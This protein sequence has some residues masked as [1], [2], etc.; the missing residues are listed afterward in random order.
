MK[1]SEDESM[2]EENREEELVYKECILGIDDLKEILPPPNPLPTINF[3][4]E[5]SPTFGLKHYR[6][7]LLARPA[8][9][10]TGSSLQTLQKENDIYEQYSIDSQEMRILKHIETILAT[11]GVEGLYD[12]EY[13]NFYPNPVV[14]SRSGRTHYNSKEK[15]NLLVTF[16][17]KDLQQLISTRM[18]MESSYRWSFM[19][20]DIKIKPYYQPMN[21]DKTLVFESR[22]ESGNLGLAIKISNNEYSLLMQNDSLIKGHTQCKHFINYRVLFQS[23]QYYKRDTNKISY[24]QFRKFKGEFYSQRLIHYTRVG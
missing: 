1:S 16:D 21:N 8:F 15:S 12:L 6:T 9:N 2:N 14:Y 19:D 13:S 18:K 24:T 7:K 10:C 11:V 3:S 23:C 20:K 17:T 4:S 5:E 22:F